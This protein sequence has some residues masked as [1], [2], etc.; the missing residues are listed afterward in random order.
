M[1]IGRPNCRRSLAY[2]AAR[3]VQA[4][5]H[6]N[7][8]GG[9]DRAGEVEHRLTGAA[10]DDARSAVE[11]HACRTP[12]GV[13]VRRGLDRDAGT[14]SVD[15]DD[16]VPGRHQEDVGQPAAEHDARGAGR[17]SVLDQE[18]AVQPDATGQ[19]ARGEPWQEPLTVRIVTAGID[20][21]AREH[22]GGEGAW[23]Q[24]PPELLDDHDQLG[25]AEARPAERL[26]QVQAQPAHAADLVPERGRLLVRG[27]EQL[28]AAAS[29]PRAVS[30][31]WTL[32][33][34]ARWSSVMAMDIDAFP[35][36]RC[37][38]VSPRT[39]CEGRLRT[40]RVRTPPPHAPSLRPT[41][42]GP[43]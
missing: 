33:A 18:V 13:E 3:S 4:R 21:G 40:R 8:L 6:A 11:G 27:L 7:G 10:Q 41:P 28:A 16:V 36:G 43:R 32:A 15:D 5:G 26:G 19:L 39:W 17:G 2:A 38:D 24:R 9:E 42:G 25:E 1:A 35:C 29:E 30:R 20:R 23:G 34:R 14:R 31:S 12:R 37:A 22:R